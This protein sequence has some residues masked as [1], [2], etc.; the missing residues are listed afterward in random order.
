[1]PSSLPGVDK[2]L[3]RRPIFRARNFFCVPDQAREKMGA[4]NQFTRLIET[5]LEKL[6]LALAAF[7]F[8]VFPSKVS[9]MRLL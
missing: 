9:A 1:M 6:L 7:I 5:Q 3:S 4:Q 2:F 8:N